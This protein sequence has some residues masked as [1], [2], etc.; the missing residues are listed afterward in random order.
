MVVFTNILM[1]WLLPI[2]SE[3]Q[4]SQLGWAIMGFIISGIVVC[5]ICIVIKKTMFIMCERSIK[6]AEKDVSGDNI[7]KEPDFTNRNGVKNK[8]N[9][10][11]EY[12]D[13]D[14]DKLDEDEINQLQNKRQVMGVD[15]QKKSTSGICKS[16]GCGV[17]TIKKN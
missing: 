15:C 14:E 9:L 3:D 17:D 8:Q 5:W 7:I 6:P 4:M 12:D 2:Q 16:Q 1:F 13:I 11:K 10:E